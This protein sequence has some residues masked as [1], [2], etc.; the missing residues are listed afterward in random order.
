MSR[1][2]AFYLVLAGLFVSTTASAGSPWV[3]APEKSVVQFD[4]R[5]E[6]ADREF[7]PDGTN[8]DFPLRGSFQGQTL[9]FT[10][11][12]GLGHGLE[13]GFAGSYK[14]LSY[15]SDP[16]TVVSQAGNDGVQLLPTFSLSEEQKGLGDLILSLRYN[17]LGGA[18]LI[19]PEV[20]VKIPTGYE[21]PAGTFAGD[22]PGIAVDEDGA[23]V[24]QRTGDVPVLDDLAL[25]D[26]Q[27]DATGALLFGTYIKATKTFG[28]ADVGF[29]Y[30]FS[31]PAPTTTYGVK[32]GQFIGKSFVMFAGVNGEQRL[33]KGEPIGLSFATLQPETSA[34]AFPVGNFKLFTLRRDKS[35]TEVSGGGLLRLSDYEI[36]LSGGRILDGKNVAESTFVSL[37]TSYRY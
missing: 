8:Q 24:E 22:N 19:T 37:S 14:G 6:F 13:L 2:I 25:G 10:F 33:G 35:F 7:L 20:E 34:Q 31:G 29:K 26:A 9:G 1:H 21:G 28:K 17:L 32:L 5:S 36:I 3:L 4:F 18:I 30:R 23:F 16:V 27:V 11:R 12:H 15:V